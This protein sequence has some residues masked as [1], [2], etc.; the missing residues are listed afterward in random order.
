[1]EAANV[2]AQV[3][4]VVKAVMVVVMVVMAVMAILPLWNRRSNFQSTNLPFP[5]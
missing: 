2:S 4:T 1:M 3:E 5:K